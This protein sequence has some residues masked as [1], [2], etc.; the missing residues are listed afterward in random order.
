MMTALLRLTWRM[1]RW[2]VAVLVGGTLLL[3]ALAALVAWQTAVTTARLTACYVDA[4]GGP[5]SPDCR[6]LIG[7]GNILTEAGPI[8]VG[9][10]A[11]VPFVVGLLLGAP[12]VSREL[13]KRTAPMAWSL[14]RSRSRWLAIRVLPLLVALTVALLLL[15]QASESLILAAPSNNELGF[16]VFAMH[17]PLVAVRGVATFCIGL[18]VGLVVGR[19]LP[20]I[21]VTGVLAIVLVAGVT[22]WRGELMRAE[23]AW[24]PNSGEGDF[25]G[26]LVY[27]QAFLDA[28]TGERLPFDTVFERYPDVFG[29][30]G[31]GIPPGMS[32]ASLVTPPERYPVF[33]AREMG[34]LLLVS[35]LAGG[36]TLWLLR[37]RR[38]DLG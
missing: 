18:L 35:V 32:L 26:I 25:S 19:M 29:P 24:V 33:V 21:L 16:R 28:A 12:L 13:E 38:P 27:D 10:T 14:S 6:S 31:S 5:L 20:A 8:L 30:T 1:Q 2:E 22:F 34:V 15:G 7:W 4:A 9:A 11:V 36:A 37:S 23:A 3:A 17:G